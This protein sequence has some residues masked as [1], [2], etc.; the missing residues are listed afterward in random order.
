MTVVLDAAFLSDT[1]RGDTKGHALLEELADAGETAIVPSIVAA[2]YL[3][4]SQDAEADLDALEAAAVLLSFGKEDAVAAADIARRLFLR[5][6]FPGWVDV[7]IAGFAKARGNLSVVTRNVRH[8][9]ET[10]L[11]T[12]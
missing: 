8:F 6:V 4:G 7:M 1:R 3:S 9:P 2:E 11:R 5:G 10:P 12:Y